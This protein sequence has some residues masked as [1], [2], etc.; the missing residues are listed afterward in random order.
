MKALEFYNQV[1]CKLGS[2]KIRGHAIVGGYARDMYFGFKPKDMDVCVVP[3]ADRVARYDIELKSQELGLSTEYFE[4]YDSTNHKQ[5]KEMLY[6][7]LRVYCEDMQVDI[8]I[9]KLPTVQDYIDAFDYN[10]NQYA[11]NPQGVPF[12]AGLPDLNPTKCN[13]LLNLRRDTIDER[14]EK[15]AKK[16]V[17]IYNHMRG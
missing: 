4:C 9:S 7:V 10:L 17:A 12:Y 16:W 1:I 11:I 3:Y 2:F 5:F 14:K 6:G 8:L 13:L 15:M